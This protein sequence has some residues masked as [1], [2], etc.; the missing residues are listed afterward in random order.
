MTR[1][2]QSGMDTELK[3]VRLN[4]VVA[5]SQVTAIDEW[6]RAQPDLP[7]RSEAIRK[8]VELGLAATAP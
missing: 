7:S 3:S 4:L 6:R 5:P 8:L 2:S 1:D